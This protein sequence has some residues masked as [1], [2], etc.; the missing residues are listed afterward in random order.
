MIVVSPPYYW[1]V[2]D[3]A[4][5]V[6]SRCGVKGLCST[7]GYGVICTGCANWDRGMGVDPKQWWRKEKG[8]E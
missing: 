1:E 3:G 2:P 7:P 4:L 6:C 5:I 8:E